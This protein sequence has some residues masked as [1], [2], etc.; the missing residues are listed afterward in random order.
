MHSNQQKDLPC[1]RSMFYQ[2]LLPY[3]ERLP[4]WELRPLNQEYSLFLN[5]YIMPLWFAIKLSPSIFHFINYTRQGERAQI[6]QISTWLVNRD[7]SHTLTL[8]MK[9][10]VYATGDV[11]TLQF[12]ICQK[13]NYHFIHNITNKID[14]R[15]S[16][17]ENTNQTEM[18]AIN[19]PGKQNYQIMWMHLPNGNSLKPKMVQKKNFQLQ[20]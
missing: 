9:A 6:C 15:N 3:Q 2:S 20:I 5:N 19:K 4:S 10:I 13:I 12:Y 17:D 18:P 16:A 11:F 14:I 8:Y 1:A 7:F